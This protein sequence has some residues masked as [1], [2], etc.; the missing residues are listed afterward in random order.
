MTTSNARDLKDREEEHQIIVEGM[1]TDYEERVDTL[2]RQ[3]IDQ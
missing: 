3:M 2:R 1:K